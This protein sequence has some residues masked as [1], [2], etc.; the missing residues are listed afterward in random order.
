MT[1]ELG[2]I[3]KDIQADPGFAIERWKPVS[4]DGDRPHLLSGNETLGIGA[5]ALPDER[6]ES[7]ASDTT[8]SHEA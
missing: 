5:S 2:A 8:P 6:A 1:S 3:I 7:V 4:P